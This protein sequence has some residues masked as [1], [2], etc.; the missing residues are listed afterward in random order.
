MEPQHKFEASTLAEV[1]AKV[2]SELGPG[3]KISDAQRVR[4]GGV[5]G[6]FQRERF[7]VTASPPPPE[8]VPPTA[9]HDTREAH[10]S[11]DH[12]A[13]EHAPR[14][15]LELAEDMNSTERALD[16]AN[17]PSLAAT[18]V[19]E[20]DERVDDDHDY[21]SFADIL[22][23]AS[24]PAYIQSSSPNQT[25]RDLEEFDELDEI[26]HA[27][28]D[29]E[30]DDLP[31]DELVTEDLP[32]DDYE[33]VF[34]DDVDDLED[35]FEDNVEEDNVEA[36]T[37]EQQINATELYDPVA[38]FIRPETI[39]PAS[40]E[41]KQLVLE[42]S[43][44]ANSEP[45]LGPEIIPAE[46][47]VISSTETVQREAPEIYTC[48]ADVLSDAVP[49]TSLNTNTTTV[50]VALTRHLSLEFDLLERS[51]ATIDVENLPDDTPQIEIIPESFVESDSVEIDLE[52]ELEPEAE[53]VA[54]P[55]LEPEPEAEPAPSPSPFRQ[56][57]LPDVLCPAPDEPLVTA[58]ERSLPPLPTIAPARG[59]V[60]CIVGER[61]Q[62]LALATHLDTDGTK[63]EMVL[64]I[65]KGTKSRTIPT[66]KTPREA[67]N[68]R[69]SWSRRHQLTV[70]VVESAPSVT[71]CTWTDDMLTAFEPVLTYAVVSATRKTEDV[72]NW[73]NAIG[74][75]DCLAITDVDATSTPASPFRMELPIAFI[76]NAPASPLAIAHYLEARIIQSEPATPPSA[77]IVADLPKADDLR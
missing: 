54:E 33:N 26:N 57:G 18:A 30:L 34:D 21:E 36:V 77:H 70:V 28:T 43:S 55:E 22:E 65:E 3:A 11:D 2:Q 29:D 1:L 31:V 5:M 37:D 4:S 59:N 10:D 32:I 52:P 41:G 19:I 72:G 15:L 24:S 48:I 51:D 16:S 13:S 67:T 56:L 63:P 53:L 38:R 75:V 64:A 71:P 7:V 9:P 25:L 45:P 58:L 69:R 14:S 6:F 40:D 17:A 74:G 44:A 35:D 23:R 20:S 49:E 66:M 61:E 76:D 60:V 8:P 47:L 68:A 62:A 50:D 73:I 39:T 46:T 27:V 12:H 42:V